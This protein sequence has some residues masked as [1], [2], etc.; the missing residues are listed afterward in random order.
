[1]KQF[2][3]AAL[4]A[5]FFFT[6]AVFAADGQPKKLILMA[7]KPSHPP[8]M[9]EF[10]AGVQLLAKCL[11]NA[12]SVKTEVIL[13]GWPKDEKAFDG[14]DAVVFYM[15]GGAKHEAVQEGRRRLDM[16]E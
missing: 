9:H 12:P 6:T 16:I 14:T 13:N 10:N 3:T 15:D 4:L 11:S 1:M 8:R 7:G 5:S 2:I